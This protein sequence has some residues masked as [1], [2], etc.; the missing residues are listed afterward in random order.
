ML[1]A[2]HTGLAAYYLR[3]EEQE[4]L[5]K[6]A[7][8]VLEFERTK[9]IVSRRLPDPP[10]LVADIGGGPGR[11][12]QWLAELGYQVEHRDLMPLHITQLRAGLAADALV[13]S[14]VGD[15]R[16]LD[17]ADASVDAVLLLG[18]LYHLRRPADRIQA[19][20][21]A[22]RIVR[23]GGPVFAAAIS[24]WAPRLDGVLHERLYLQIP[25]ILGAV[26]ELEQ[27]GWMPPVEPGAFTAYFHR[28]DEL[29]E[30]VR[31][32]GLAVADLVTVEGTAYL[33]ADLAARL[34]NPA[35]AAVVFDALRA[36]ERVPELLGVGP[37]LVATGI[38]QA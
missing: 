8:G 7:P 16:R 36:V 9:E 21:E 6:D 12:T 27:D 19:L 31:A 15:A 37:H 18:P 13:R 14:E 17:L 5:A 10:A 26:A 23:P 3:G 4:R 28:P 38:R 2:E 20:R 32:A 11:Y 33:L 1:E 25:A 30:E 29:R 22:A 35:E 24:R 34:A